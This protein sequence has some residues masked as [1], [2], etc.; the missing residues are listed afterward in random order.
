MHPFDDEHGKSISA[1]FLKRYDETLCRSDY[2][3]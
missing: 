1:I 2:E 3:V